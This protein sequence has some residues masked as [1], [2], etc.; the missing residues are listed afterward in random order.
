MSVDHNTHAGDAVRRRRKQLRLSQE[1]ASAAA[2]VS[3][4][5]WTRAERGEPLSHLSETG[6]CVALGW[7]DGSYTALRRGG[8]CEIVVPDKASSVVAD[9]RIADLERRLMAIEKIVGDC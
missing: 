1:E 8:C 7:K 9:R 4:S 6:L 2:A 5:T 3:R